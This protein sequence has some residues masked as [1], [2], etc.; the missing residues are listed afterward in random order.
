MP[1]LRI[2]AK[3]V[4]LNLEKTLPGASH[5][6]AAGGGPRKSACGERGAVEEGVQC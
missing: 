3:G 6:G 1:A 4:Q 5:Q 2:F